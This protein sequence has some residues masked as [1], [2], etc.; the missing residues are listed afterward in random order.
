MD[1][2]LV[3]KFRD[4]GL[5]RKHMGSKDKIHDIDGPRD[6][7]HEPEFV[8]PITV[9]QISNML[10]V[11]FG[12]RPK[13][14]RRTTVYDRI[15]Y[16]FEKAL[17]S[18]LKID[19]I[20]DEKGRFPREFISLAKSQ[21]NSYSGVSYVNWNR[22]NKLLEDELYLEFTNMINEIFGEDLTKKSFDDALK[23]LSNSEDP[24]M[25]DVLIFLKKNK[26]TPLYALIKDNEDISMNANARTLITN[27]KGVDK[28]RRLEGS[29]LVPVTD[30]DI[31]NIKENKGCATI[32]DGG[33]VSI[34]GIE[35]GDEIN[36]LNYRKVSEIS[37]E[38]Q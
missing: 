18:Y 8:E 11:L 26:K 31:L 29:I 19:T 22:I 3:L 20:K 15:D 32:L 10:H 34:H 7:K 5:F 4:A 36:P 25:E 33:F 17:D 30:S 27:L 13:P 21:W 38:E 6:R 2:F 16:I 35:Y 24:R 12:E 14:S 9:H 37:L 23:M 28:I 1:K